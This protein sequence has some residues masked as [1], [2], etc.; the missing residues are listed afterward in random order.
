MPPSCL[1]HSVSLFPL[2]FNINVNADMRHHRV[3]LVFQDSPLQQ[4][5]R[6]GE[7]GGTQV[8]LD[9]VHSMRLMDWWHPQYPSS[10]YT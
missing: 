7:Q 3:C 6:K 5:R 4:G 10:P 2:Q 1:T 9:P 8:V